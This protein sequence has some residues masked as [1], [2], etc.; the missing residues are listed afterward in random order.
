[1]QKPAQ[2][3]KMTAV[4]ELIDVSRQPETNPVTEVVGMAFSDL[5]SAV[6]EKARVRPLAKKKGEEKK[7]KKL[8][9]QEKPLDS[10][11]ASL[12]KSA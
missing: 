3:D 5:K 11:E 8:N 2:T 6:D 12:E 7:P 10:A 4:K 9:V 1:M